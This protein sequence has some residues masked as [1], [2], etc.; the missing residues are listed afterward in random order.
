M[1]TIT[2][3]AKGQIDQIQNCKIMPV[4][5]MHVFDMSTSLRAVV[6]SLSS[7]CRFMVL[8][9][10]KLTG[11]KSASIFKCPVHTTQ[12]NEY[13]QQAKFYSNLKYSF[14]YVGIIL[15]PISMSAS[16]NFFDRVPGQCERRAEKYLCTGQALIAVG[17]TI[18]NYVL[19]WEQAINFF[20][21]FIS[22]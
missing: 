20:F 14:L 5:T 13:H 3:L 16:I 19:T 6:L 21:L 9:L 17:H 10:W 8:H 11:G 12:V 1:V 18:G 22:L 15:N 4:S 2:I 7:K